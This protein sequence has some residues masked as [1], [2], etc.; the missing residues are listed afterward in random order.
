MAV[1]ASLALQVEGGRCSWKRGDG[2]AV[3]DYGQG[4]VREEEMS[5]VEDRL[6]G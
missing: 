3:W 6:V 4:S 5:N 1:R 2:R